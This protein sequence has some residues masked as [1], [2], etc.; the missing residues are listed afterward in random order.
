MVVVVVVVGVAIPHGGCHFRHV[1]RF[2]LAKFCNSTLLHPVNSMPKCQEH[3]PNLELFPH[4][5]TALNGQRLGT[6]S[7]L[8]TEAQAITQ[9][10][11][12]IP[13]WSPTAWSRT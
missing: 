6:L 12:V 2:C 13:N 8:H 1:P 5:E 9:T 7:F 11:N 10:S 4:L 3:Y